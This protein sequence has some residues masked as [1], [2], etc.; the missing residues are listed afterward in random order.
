MAK[1]CETLKNGP[2][3]FLRR[4][5][6]ELESLDVRCQNLSWIKWLERATGARYFPPLVEDLSASQLSPVMLAVLKQSPEK[7]VGLLQAHWNAEYESTTS[8]LPSISSK[9]GSCPVIC[10]SKAKMQLQST[11]LPS[12]E[13]KAEANKLG[14][15]NEFPFLKL[16]V[17]LSRTNYRHWRCL[18]DLGV[19]HKVD[20][21]FYKLVLEK[22][23]SSDNV[24]AENVADV[25]SCMAKIVQLKEQK[26]L[27]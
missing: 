8:K 7:F 26:D 19:G 6:V 22:M 1:G 3:A 27:R 13:V 9:L 18:E 5:L 16:P 12:N 23:K 14:V 21:R 4:E 20:L 10:E 25:Y 15:E 11:Y 24:T 2:A 17:T